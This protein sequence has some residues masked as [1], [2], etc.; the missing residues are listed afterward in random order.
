[1]T[2]Q[3]DPLD[4]ILKPFM[5]GNLET[6]AIGAAQKMRVAEAHA[7]IQ[8]HYNARFEG[9]LPGKKCNSWRCRA[10]L[11]MSGSHADDCDLSD[12]GQARAES[13]RARWYSQEGGTNDHL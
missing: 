9:V 13:M 3:P 12:L 10:T 8:A 5:P 7:A 11:S 4:E 2:K 6:P 1:M